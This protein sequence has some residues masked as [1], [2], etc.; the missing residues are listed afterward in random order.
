MRF[1]S[2]IIE[3]GWF[4]PDALPKPLLPFVDDSVQAALRGLLHWHP[5]E[6]IKYE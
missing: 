6:T 5:M 4:Y 1:S 2:E 3:A